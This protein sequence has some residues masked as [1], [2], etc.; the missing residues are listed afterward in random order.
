MYRL[1]CPLLLNKQGVCKKTVGSHSK[2]THHCSV[3]S[4]RASSVRQKQ[5]ARCDCVAIQ[6]LDFRG[7]WRELKVFP[8]NWKKKKKNLEE[9]CGAHQAFEDWR[10]CQ[11]T[12]EIWREVE[13]SEEGSAAHCQITSSRLHQRENNATNLS[14]FNRRWAL[15][16]LLTSTGFMTKAKSRH[17]RFVGRTWVNYAGNN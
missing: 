10:L 14:P 6:A 17:L 2:Y 11:S 1:F 15:L 16:R 5:Q 7:A 3:I 4:C 8:K 12:A 9:K 13:S